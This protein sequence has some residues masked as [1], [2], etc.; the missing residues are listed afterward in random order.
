[1]QCETRP[2]G[3]H[4]GPGT[5]IFNRDVATLP[6]TTLSV[7]KYAHASANQATA[8]LWRVASV[9]WTCPHPYATRLEMSDAAAPLI[10]PALLIAYLAI[11]GLLFWGRAPQ[12]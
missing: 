11:G 5:S 3:P 6:A 9:T 4:V 10:A 2:C 12:R 7:F 1:M 8:Y